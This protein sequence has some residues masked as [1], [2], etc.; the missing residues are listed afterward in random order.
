MGGDLYG[1]PKL[2]ARVNAFFGPSPGIRRRSQIHRLQQLKPF[3]IQAAV[4]GSRRARFHLVGGIDFSVCGIEVF[5][6][7][8]GSRT[9]RLGVDGQHPRLDQAGVFHVSFR[10]MIARMG[11]VAF[12]D[13]AVF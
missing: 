8:L 10:E 5:G 9:D 12:F 2:L 11:V 4:I 1:Q 7:L 6:H 13:P 3:L